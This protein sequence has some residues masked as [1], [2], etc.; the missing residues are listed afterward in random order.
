MTPGSAPTGNIG[1]SWFP[2]GDQNAHMRD[3]K[4]EC[5]RGKWHP[6]LPHRNPGDL[7]T[8]C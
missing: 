4:S 1:A 7:G 6:S 2:E 3:V 5:L 8:M